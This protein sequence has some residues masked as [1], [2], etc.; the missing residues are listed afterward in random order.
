MWVADPKAFFATVAV[1][2]VAYLFLSA[3]SPT[4]AQLCGGA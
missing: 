1:V 2:V 3:N 4:L